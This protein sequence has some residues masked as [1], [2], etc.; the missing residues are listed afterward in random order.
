MTAHA[1]RLISASKTSEIPE[2]LGIENDGKFAIR[3]F[4]CAISTSKSKKNFHFL[5]FY[6][7]IYGNSLDLVAKWP[8]FDNNDRSSVHYFLKVERLVSTI[9]KFST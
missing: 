7:T 1:Q 5:H 2:H 9:P 4:R 8:G 6:L 3:G